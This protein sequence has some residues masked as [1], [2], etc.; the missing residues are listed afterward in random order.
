MSELDLN[1]KR[2]L[3][4]AKFAEAVY[5]VNSNTNTFFDHKVIDKHH[6]VSYLDGQVTWILTRKDETVYLIIRGTTSTT[7]I[8]TDLAA[9]QIKCDMIGMPKSW[10]HT[11]MVAQA[12]FVLNTIKNHIK[13]GIILSNKN[14]RLIVCGHSLGASVSSLVT[15]SLRAQYNGCD[16]S[17]YGFATAPCLDWDTANWSYDNGNFLSIANLKDPVPNVRIKLGVPGKILW[18]ENAWQENVNL[19]N[20][21]DFWSKSWFHPECANHHKI[22]KY[23]ESINKLIQINWRYVSNNKVFQND[24]V[25]HIKGSYKNEQGKFVTINGDGWCSHSNQSARD[26]QWKFEPIR[27]G[28]YRIKSNIGKYQGNY[29]LSF[30]SGTGAVG[31][32]SNGGTEW[33][34]IYSH[35]NKYYVQC[36]NQSKAG[37]WLSRSNRNWCYLYNNKKDASLYEI[38]PMNK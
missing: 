27:N 18:M 30:R 1:P 29:V 34:L 20:A 35:E 11:G 21:N 2:L 38:I 17:G 23:I 6:S 22:E 32:Y 25:Y 16:I 5:N 7:D 13:N 4:L 31:M 26:S 10:G 36:N 3:E 24:N 9:T 28:I 14:E 19:M 8:L 37:C 12:L 15:L 33:Q